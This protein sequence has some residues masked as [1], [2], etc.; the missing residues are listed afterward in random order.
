[1]PTAAAAAHMGWDYYNNNKKS[2]SD[3][4]EISDTYDKLVSVLNKLD[5]YKIPEFIEWE[6]NKK[7]AINV[8]RSIESKH[9]RD[10]FLD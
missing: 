2:F 5:F 8:I 10:R 6:K 1:M 3:L 9:S 7:D 4:K